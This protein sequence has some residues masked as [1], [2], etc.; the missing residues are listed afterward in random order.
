LLPPHCRVVFL[1]NRGFADI[2]LT[3][4]LKRMG[5]PYRIRIKSSFLIHRRGH[6]CCKVKRLPWLV[7]RRVSGTM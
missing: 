2:D 7:G 1:A 3:I 4:G 5:W 6:R